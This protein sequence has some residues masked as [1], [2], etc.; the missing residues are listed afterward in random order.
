MCLGLSKDL[1]KQTVEFVCESR[2]FGKALSEHSIIKDKIARIECDLYTMESMIYMTAG[3]QDSYQ[4]ADIAC[5]SALTKIY[6][7]ETMRKIVNECLDILAMSQYDSRWID[8][9]RA[10]N[11]KDANYL[12]NMF[13]TNDMLKLYVANSGLINAGLEVNS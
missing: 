6:C 8:E 4:Q 11:L 7:T 1:F 13:H 9:H 12:I 10:K 2:R 3:I 5:E